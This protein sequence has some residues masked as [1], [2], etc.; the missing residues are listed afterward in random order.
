MVTAQVSR[1]WRP[2]RT[3]EVHSSAPVDRGVG[4]LEE[5]WDGLV[6]VAA[7]GGAALKSVRDP[8]GPV[9]GP[10]GVGA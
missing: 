10:A 2:F 7:G 9:A 3:V 4:A 1:P 5:G 6:L 8:T